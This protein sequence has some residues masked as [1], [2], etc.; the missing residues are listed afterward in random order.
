L[1]APSWSCRWLAA[2]PLQTVTRAL[3]RVLVL[4]TGG[5]LGMDPDASYAHD[6]DGHVT[7][8][9]GTGGRYHGG[10]RPGAP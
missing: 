10:L 1:G 3:P 4:H 2:G 9:P 6:S 5:T 8:K 7:L